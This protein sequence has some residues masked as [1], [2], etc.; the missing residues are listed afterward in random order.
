M[1]IE[2]KLLANEIRKACGRKVEGKA[3]GMSEGGKNTGA[4]F[5]AEQL[6]PAVVEGLGYQSII[7]SRARVYDVSSVQ[8]NLFIQPWFDSSLEDEPSSGTRAYWVG[9]A[10]TKTASVPA[11]DALR[12][13]LGK[14]CVK[15][16]LTDELLEDDE[17]LVDYIVTESVS[18]LA[19]KIDKAGF[20]GMAKPIRGVMGD[21]DGATLTATA[22]NDIT[23]TQ[24]IGFLD[25]IHPMATAAEWFISKAQ[26]SNIL[27]LAYD[28]SN[29]L[30]FDANIGRY[31]LFGRPVTVVPGLVANPYHVCLA[32][33][34]RYVVFHKA[35]TIRLD[36]HLNFETDQTTILVE[37][38]IAGGMAV[39]VSELDDTN[40]Y[41]W[42]VCPNGGE[43][44]ASSSS[45]SSSL[46]SESSES[47]ESSLGISSKSSLSSL[48]ISSESS[49]TPG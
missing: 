49:N 5:L 41:A 27:Y 22:S 3:A 2:K 39:N 11:T 28:T 31:R 46:S 7:M 25:L 20:L 30:V 48:G 4:D 34:S 26:E 33:F 29:A 23:D 10:G 21:G 36:P 38:R 12:L 19:Q 6:S 45:S 40:G 9:E 18:K 15:V 8:G 44:G 32:D 35:V 37:M 17:R 24:I 43:A 14:L 47:S 1:K 16:T 42:V 13:Q